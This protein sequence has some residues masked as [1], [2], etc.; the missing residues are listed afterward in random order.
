MI[1][2][3]FVQQCDQATNEENPKGPHY[4]DFVTMADW[5]KSFQRVYNVESDFTISF[6]HVFS[7]W[8]GTFCY[9]ILGF[10][11]KF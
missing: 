3:L 7:P 6:R 11:T 10:D 8:F 2:P 1:I 4:R 9:Q 5:W